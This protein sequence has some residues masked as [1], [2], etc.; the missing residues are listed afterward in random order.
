MPDSPTPAPIM[1]RVPLHHLSQDLRDA[2]QALE[3]AAAHIVTANNRLFGLYEIVQSR[4]T[5]EAPHEKPT[6]YLQPG[7]K[8]LLDTADAKKA[9]RKYLRIV[10]YMKKLEQ[11]WSKTSEELN[12]AF[13][14]LTIRF[15]E[16][17]LVLSQFC[18]FDESYR[19][20][21]HY[22]TDRRDRDPTD[23]RQGVSRHEWA[24]NDVQRVINHLEAEWLQVVHR[25][26]AKDNAELKR[27]FGAGALQSLHFLKELSRLAEACESFDRAAAAYET[28][29]SHRLA[30]LP[31]PKKA[32][33]SIEDLSGAISIIQEE[34]VSSGLPPQDSASAG[35]KLLA[36]SSSSQTHV[37]G[38]TVLD[39]A[40]GYQE[41]TE[42]LANETSSAI[43]PLTDGKRNG[44]ERVPLSLQ[45]TNIQAAPVRQQ[46]IESLQ[47]TGRKRL[48]VKSAV[49]SSKRLKIDREVGSSPTSLLVSV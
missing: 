27:T 12:Q 24:V 43:R 46:R 47:Q 44:I 6:D 16:L 29:K 30:Q 14:S 40:S 37:Q 26:W 28:A 10:P 1:A 42:I 49:S 19:Q 39:E 23:K 15:A 25:T 13:G 9:Y 22:A 4:F 7:T 5:S 45:S 33:W 11:K 21:L 35:S 20:L 31:E 3:H 48:Q 34:V 38:S 32:S 18:G 2:L 36:A 17:L 8:E 41:K